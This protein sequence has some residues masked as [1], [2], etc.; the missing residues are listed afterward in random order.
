[1]R[2]ENYV[3][4]SMHMNDIVGGARCGRRIG[5]EVLAGWAQSAQQFRI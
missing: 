2:P 1:M 5:R 3:H 4:A